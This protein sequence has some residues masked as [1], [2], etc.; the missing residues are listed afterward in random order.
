MEA[1]KV[2]HAGRIDTF[3]A[4]QFLFDHFWQQAKV[5]PA[6]GVFSVSV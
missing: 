1:F 6:T 2:E 5:R 4:I 3:I